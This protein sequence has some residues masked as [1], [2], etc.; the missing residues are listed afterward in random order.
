MQEQKADL[1]LGKV[2]PENIK[3][4]EGADQKSLQMRRPPQSLVLNNDTE[5]LPPIN[6]S[7]KTSQP[8]PECD[9]SE[10]TTFNIPQTPVSRPRTASPFLNHAIT[11][12]SRGRR[13]LEYYM[14]AAVLN[15]M[16]TSRTASE[17]AINIS[18]SGEEFDL[19]K[20]NLHRCPPAKLEELK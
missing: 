17:G 14:Q 5:N 10:S 7:P 20:E 3:E 6:S 19:C 8:E 9:N 11:V 15:L 18:S 2:P 12:S 4:S 13:S 16:S 1:E